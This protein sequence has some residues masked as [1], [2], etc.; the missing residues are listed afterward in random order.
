M[1]ER[2]KKLFF[3]TKLSKYFGGLK[4]FYIINCSDES[5]DIINK[6]KDDLLKK[7]LYFVRLRNSYFTIVRDENSKKYFDTISGTNYVVIDFHDRPF[8][9]STIYDILAS[10]RSTMFL[11]GAR[12]S[13]FFCDAM[14]FHKLVY[15][16]NRS[17]KM[18]QLC[19]DFDSFRIDFALQTIKPIFFNIIKLIELQKDTLNKRESPR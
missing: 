18:S 9:H 17:Y 11:Y 10:N 14:R 6:V 1:N 15:F 4:N 8:T 13:G 12:C 5:P 19:H 16:E 7:N 3:L 2:I